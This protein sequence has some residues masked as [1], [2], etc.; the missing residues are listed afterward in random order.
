MKI[1]YIHYHLKPGGV[2]TVIRQQVEA[3]S[4]HCRTIVLVG[5]IPSSCRI[6]AIPIPGIAYDQSG[7]SKASPEQAADHIAKEIHSVWPE[8][9]DIIHVHNPTLAKNKNFLKVLKI[10]Q[11][12]GFNLLLQ[13]HDFAE[14]GRPQSYFP[15]AYP[16]NCHYCV[17]NSRDRDTLLHAGLVPEGLHLL[18][19]MVN[20][21]GSADRPCNLDNFILYPV[22]AIRRKNIGEAILL[23]LFFPNR[24]ALAITLPPNSPADFKSYN[25][26]K[27]FAARHDL[28]VLFE[29]SAKEDFLS[30][31]QGARLIISTSISEGFGFSFLEPWTAGQTLWGRSLPEICI[32]FQE[33]GVRLEG[34]YSRI[35]IPD[36]WVSRAKLFQ[37]YQTVI[38]NSLNLFGRESSTIDT[39]NGFDEFLSKDGLDFGMLNE[40]FQKQIITRVLASAENKKSL[41]AAN[42]FLLEMNASQD[43][44]VV[45][46]N[47]QAVLA[48]YS[49]AIYRKNLMEMYAYVKQSQVNQSIDKQ[50]LLNRFLTPSRLNLLK[51][52][53]YE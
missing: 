11:S 22:R 39:T 17:I 32:D 37:S 49:Q 31:V 47:R 51:W 4:D 53:V 5:E 6:P 42:P 26:W 9:C 18:P 52:G 43:Q 38:E 15:E 25:G 8:G 12:R 14:D 19:N 28:P 23:S 34:L 40:S 13:I 41:A 3:V 36:G 46:H 10:L 16:A 7:I 2:T 20:P 24:E 45:S 1:A 33:Q 35:V 48:N 21:V 27:A 29:A 44:T 50:K 30:L